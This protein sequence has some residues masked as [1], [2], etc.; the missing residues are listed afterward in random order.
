MKTKS[1]PIPFSFESATRTGTIKGL[2]YL[3]TE[4]KEDQNGSILQPR[5]LVQIIHGM[6]EHMG[7][8]HDFCRFLAKQGHAVCIFDL[9]GHGLS[10]NTPE[11]LGYFGYPDGNRLV[12][13]DVTKAA[14]VCQDKLTALM[15]KDVALP[16][17]LMGHSM[18]SFIARLYSIQPEAELAGAIYSG[19]SGPNPAALLGVLL[20]RW[21]ILR[22]GPRYRDEFLSRLVAKGT[23][24][25]IDSPRT[26]WDWLS[27]D[28]A[29]VDQYI[30]DPLCG[31][32]FT[33]AG[34]YDMFTW[35]RK[36]SKNSW[37]KQIPLQL[38]ILLVSGDQ[39]PIGQYGEGPKKIADRLRSSGHQVDLHLYEGGRHEM[40]NEI[41][42]ESVFNDI[43]AWLDR[44]EP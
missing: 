11:D 17:I 38:N 18:G 20:A 44:I 14:S 39:D 42:R 5:F 15:S 43:A 21:S 22:H 30:E 35:L 1:E 8:Y 23:L 31:F 37:F 26:P 7:R 25:R 34:Y 24:D 41:N 9:P 40:L 13:N 4:E 28:E 27:R 2:M 3:P 12:L 10:V 6:A 36:V 16:R 29:V 32:T 19:T 33:A